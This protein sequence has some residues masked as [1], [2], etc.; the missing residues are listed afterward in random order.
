MAR[1]AAVVE[2]SG[3]EVTYPGEPPVK[4]LR[5][6]DLTVWE[7]DYVTVV[8]PSGSGK[9]TLLNVVGLL[10]R[11]TAGHYRLDGVDASGL[12]EDQRTALRG[13]RIGFVFQPFNL[14]EHRS[15]TD[16]VMLGLLYHK[17]CATQRRQAAREMLERVSLGHRLDALPATMSGG[18]RQ[19]V[20]VARALVT[21]PALLLCDEPT[22]NLD[23]HTTNQVMDLLDDLHREG[24][25]IMA[26]THDH[27]VAQRGTRT[28]SILDGHLGQMGVRP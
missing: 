26:I 23:S 16:N 18:D 1:L 11:P 24:A 28:I 21:N 4:A 12:S 7:G 27:A 25:T 2:L 13:R 6:C 22:G 15:A 14:L 5:N 8:G 20:A 19:R 17:V 10:D 3:I 9:S